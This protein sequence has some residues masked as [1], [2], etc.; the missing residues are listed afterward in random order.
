M[1]DQIR[2]LFLEEG[3]QDYDRGGETGQAEFDPFVKGGDGKLS[4]AQ[5]YK[6][7]CGLHCPMAVGIGLDDGH[8]FA[9]WSQISF[10]AR[11][12]MGECREIDDGV[13]G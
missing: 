6:C 9:A 4:D 5:F 8:D 13:G 2:Q 11:K 7:V 12:I 1:C 3:S 10:D